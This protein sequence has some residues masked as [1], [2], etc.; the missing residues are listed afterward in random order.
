MPDVGEEDLLE[1]ILE[2]V[3]EKVSDNFNV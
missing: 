2:E 3:R 1:I